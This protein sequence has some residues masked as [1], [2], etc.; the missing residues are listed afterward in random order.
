MWTQGLYKVEMDTQKVVLLT[1]VVSSDSPLDPGTVINYAEDLDIAANGTIY[2]TDGTSI[3]PHAPD[4]EI[5]PPVN[6]AVFEVHSS[7]FLHLLPAVL[8]TKFR[9]QSVQTQDCVACVVSPPT[10]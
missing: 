6:L 9:F 4:Y 10:A 1:S 2:F 7:S 3:P 8:L 5:L